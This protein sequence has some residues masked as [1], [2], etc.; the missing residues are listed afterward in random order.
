MTIQRV[1][2]KKTDA[3]KLSA[4]SPTDFDIRR[5]QAEA[6]HEPMLTSPAGVELHFMPLGNA[7][8]YELHHNNPVAIA[9]LLE[10]HQITPLDRAGRPFVTEPAPVTT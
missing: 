7:G 10:I 6:K 3:L 8:Y 2:I 5:K 9:S 1:R 4:L